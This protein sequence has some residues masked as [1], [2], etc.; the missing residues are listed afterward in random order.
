LCGIEAR[1]SVSSGRI[2]GVA[3]D[4][5]P[6]AADQ[7]VIA[8][9]T[10]APRLLAPLGLTMSMLSQPGQLLRTNPVDLPLRHILA[11]PDQELRQE[12]D[13][14]LLAPMAAAHQSSSG[15]T[16]D[17]EAQTH[18]TLKR[19][20]NMLGLSGLKARTV[21]QANRPVPGD[22]LPVLGPVPQVA[23]L[24]LAVLHSGVTL[25]PIVAQSLGSEI[26]GQ[27]MDPLLAPFRPER[28]L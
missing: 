2:T 23:G 9:G 1:L 19:I 25:A 16:A 7:V 21:V 28:L 11:S 17:H 5:G 4:H 3:T 22:G 27:G 13:G 12:D 24:W 26:A 6:I 8:A 20:S 14:S 15:D 18:A 10:G